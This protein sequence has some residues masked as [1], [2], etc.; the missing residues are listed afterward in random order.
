VP[1]QIG[2]AENSCNSLPLSATTL[3]Y[4]DFFVQNGVLPTKIFN[5]YALPHAATTF[6]A[7]RRRHDCNEA[8]SEWSGDRGPA[9]RE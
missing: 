1:V 5:D 9:G 8:E 7:G 2:A 6:L 3:K 4:R